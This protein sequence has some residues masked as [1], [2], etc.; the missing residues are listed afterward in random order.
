MNKKEREYLKYLI[1]RYKVSPPNFND[2]IA[3]LEILL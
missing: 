2:V 1:V 3:D